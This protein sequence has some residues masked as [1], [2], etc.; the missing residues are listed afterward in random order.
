[1][2]EYQVPEEILSALRDAEEQLIRGCPLG[3]LVDVRGEKRPYQRTLI[4]KTYSNRS[5]RA[6][7]P[8]RRSA[9]G[10]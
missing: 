8:G 2:N 5:E 1:V 9:F 6:I 10:Q 4:P 3:A 7:A